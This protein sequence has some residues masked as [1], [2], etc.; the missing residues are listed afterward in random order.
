MKE[1]LYQ[2]GFTL[3]EVLAA[4]SMIGLMMTSI[5]G[6][7]AAAKKYDAYNGQKVTAYNLLQEFIERE[8]MAKKFNNTGTAPVTPATPFNNFQI[9]TTQRFLYSN[10]KEVTV[11]ISWPN[12]YGRTHQEQLKILRANYN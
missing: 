7:F 6:A 10:L 3:V 4:L 5:L 1:I 2:R 9:T 8:V 12:P 11:T